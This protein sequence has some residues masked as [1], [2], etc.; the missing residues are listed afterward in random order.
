MSEISSPGTPTAKPVCVFWFVLCLRCA[1][2]PEISFK[3]LHPV[4][5]CAY[6]CICTFCVLLC[7]GVG[8]LVCGKMGVTARLCR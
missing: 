8:V 5:V 3:Y 1:G 2:Y 6:D 4:S 7:V